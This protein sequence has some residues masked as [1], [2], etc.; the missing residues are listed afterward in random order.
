[1]CMQPL[2]FQ[3]YKQNK[4]DTSQSDREQRFESFKFSYY[5]PLI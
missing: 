5:D 3:I 4:T 1:M 2:T